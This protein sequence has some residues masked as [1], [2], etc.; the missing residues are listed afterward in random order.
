MLVDGPDSFRLTSDEGLESIFILLT[1]SGDCCHPPVRHQLT[2][3]ITAV[4]V[5]CPDPDDF[6][7]MPQAFPNSI[8]DNEMDPVVGDILRQD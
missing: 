2:R 7:A 1:L 5:S 4:R 6:V 8:L 3:S